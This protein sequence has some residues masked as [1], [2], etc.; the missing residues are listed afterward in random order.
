MQEKKS[1]ME[2]E[3]R[4][5][6]RQEQVFNPEF[7]SNMI[8]VADIKFAFEN[9]EIISLLKERGTAIKK[10]EWEDLEEIDKKI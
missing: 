3:K 9:H 5:R 1:I 6:K 2:Y 10:L 4:I 7:E 8:K